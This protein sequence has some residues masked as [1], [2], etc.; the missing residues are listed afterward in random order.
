MSG[1]AELS[2]FG[3]MRTGAYAQQALCAL[4]S[5]GPGD[6]LGPLDWLRLGTLD[7]AR[8]LG[9]EDRIGSIEAGKDADLIAVDPGATA[10]LDGPVSDVD[11]S[12]AELL[13]GR[14]IFRASDSMVRGAWVRGRRLE[15]PS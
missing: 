2:L 1:G 3:V 7:G 6:L 5:A 4:G 15:G 8:A 14:L 13:V 10:P 11:L 12:D 9:V